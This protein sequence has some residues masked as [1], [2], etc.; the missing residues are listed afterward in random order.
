[1]HCLISLWPQISFCASENWTDWQHS[2]FVKYQI[3]LFKK[4]KKDLPFK[5]PVEELECKHWQN[6]QMEDGRDE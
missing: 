3:G 6:V 2:Q 1:M 4:K 5:S